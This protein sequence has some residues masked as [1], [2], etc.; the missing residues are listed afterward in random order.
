MYIRDDIIYLTGNDSKYELYN[1]LSSNDMNIFKRI[2]ISPDARIVTLEGI[3]DDADISHWDLSNIKRVYFSDFHPTVT[4]LSKWDMSNVEHIHGLYNITHKTETLI[5]VPNLSN[6]KLDKL[7]SIN[8]VFHNVNIDWDIGK[9]NLVN[10]KDIT[11]F[12][13]N[14][15]GMNCDLSSWDFTHASLSNILTGSKDFNNSLYRVGTD[16]IPT[17]ALSNLESYNRVP[18]WDLSNIGDDFGGLFCNSVAFEQD[19][20]SIE[21]GDINDVYH[22][23][24]NTKITMRDIKDWNWDTKYPH[25]DWTEAF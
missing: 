12:L 14:T 21:L 25:I 8:N 16:N 15:T 13:T 17:Y 22:T 23:F 5:S 9:W 2:Q 7:K 1:L 18:E 20:S 6:W 3:P 24:Y 10:V 11:N 19:L 4:D